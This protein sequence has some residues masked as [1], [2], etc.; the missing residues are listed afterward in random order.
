MASCPV[1]GFVVEMN[2]APGASVSRLWNAFT[3]LLESRGLTC[4]GGGDQQLEY[5]VTSEGGQ[6]TELDRE[7]VL[8]FLAA[9]GEL[10]SYGAG[11]LVDLDR[12]AL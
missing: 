6:A 2:L 3:A 4:D 8:A 5:T 1:L 9:R 10:E 7:A 12:T 11:P